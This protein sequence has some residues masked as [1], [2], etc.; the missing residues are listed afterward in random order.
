MKITQDSFG[1]LVRPRILSFALLLTKPKN[2]SS[3]DLKKWW[4]DYSHYKTLREELPKNME[5][6]LHKTLSGIFDGLCLGET[7]KNI[8]N[9]Y[10]ATIC[11]MIGYCDGIFYHIST[12]EQFTK[13]TEHVQKTYSGK[14]NL[15]I[16]AVGLCMFKDQ[17]AKERWQPEVATPGALIHSWFYEPQ[18]LVEIEAIKKFESLRVGNLVRMANGDINIVVQSD[19]LNK[20]L[21][22]KTS[23]WACRS[24]RLLNGKA[25]SYIR[26][27]PSRQYDIV[28]NYDYFESIKNP[29]AQS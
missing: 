6:K 18:D 28:D 14:R 2:Y 10:V 13:I 24:V 11:E 25:G 12:P 29:I 17:Q 1:T 4:N 22:Y 21:F 7:N 27:L 26:L 8:E 19:L 5:S 15:S 20:Q 16:L 9:C 3:D 23:S